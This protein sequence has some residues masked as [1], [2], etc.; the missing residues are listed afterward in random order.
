MAK[1]DSLS[2][3][4]SGKMPERYLR[5][6]GTIG[7]AGQLRLLRSKVA[8]IG[9][10]GLG[11][12]VIELLARQGIGHL[13]VMDGDSFVCHN[14]N[15]QILATELTLGM[16]KA[17]AA[18]SRVAAVNSDVEVSAVP[19]MLDAGNA[20][21]LLAGM[22]VIVDALDTIS[23]RH[24]LLQ[25]ARELHI[26]LVHA[27]IAGFTGQVATVL[28]GETGIPALFARSTDSDRG[29]ETLLGNPAATPAFAAAL[30]V[31]E[32]VKLIT[33]VGQPLR[34]Q[35]LYFDLAYNLFE[36][37]QMERGE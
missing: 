15:R 14:L 9:A 24:V 28:P 18:A 35:L 12:H 4:M 23:S 7:I 3:L 32:V 33:G 17:V 26:P 27:A 5:N 34:G 13:L 8:V 30:Q 10:G 20:P 37:I 6:L 25:A 2:Q 22:D 31:Q 29:V 19:Q 11:G 21:A 36:T 16:N 1:M